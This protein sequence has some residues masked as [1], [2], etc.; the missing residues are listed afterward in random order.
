[1]LIKRLV[2]NSNT[3][4]DIFVPNNDSTNW[5]TSRPVA[6]RDK[7]SLIYI[8]DRKTCHCQGDMF[9]NLS[10]KLNMHKKQNILTVYKRKNT[11]F[12]RSIL[13]WKEIMDTIFK[14]QL[15][16]FFIEFYKFF[17]KFRKQKHI[18][19]INEYTWLSLC[20]FS[21]LSLIL[22]IFIFITLSSNGSKD[23]KQWNEN[24]NK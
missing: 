20:P 19:H 9:W 11:Q 22:Q 7:Q 21:L 15:L 4:R 3:E 17:L 2:N 6:Q 13:L 1:M 14:F 10:N 18:V 12:F 23:N 16:S 5:K 24:S 8:S